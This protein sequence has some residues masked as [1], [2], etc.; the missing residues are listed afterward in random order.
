M[1]DVGDEKVVDM[2]EEHDSKR[3]K[4]KEENGDLAAPAGA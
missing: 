1:E 3:S 2:A 4:T